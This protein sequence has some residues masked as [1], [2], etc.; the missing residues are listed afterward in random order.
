MTTNVSRV[1]SDREGGPVD[2]R[3]RSF[4][5]G[6]APPDEG[7]AR[8][9]CR[10]TPDAE[11]SGRS[12]S[13]SATQAAPSCRSRPLRAPVR[14]RSDASSGG[15][16]HRA[17]SICGAWQRVLRDV[18][19]GRDTD[20]SWSELS[21]LIHPLM[22]TWARHSVLRLRQPETDIEGI[23]QDAY[24]RLLG[25]NC[26]AMR[27]CRAHT[28]RQIRAYLRCVCENIATDRL[29]RDVSARRGGGRVVALDEWTEWGVAEEQSV[30]CR[31]SGRRLAPVHG[32]DDPEQSL[33]ARERLRS[34]ERDVDACAQVG[35][36]PERNAWIFRQAMVHG[37]RTRAIAAEVGLRCSS[38]DSVVGRMRR[39]LETRGWSFPRRT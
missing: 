10:R 8:E 31:R 3:L 7:R 20:R 28:E 4:R 1:P 27:R 38:V 9:G 30:G 2:V 13:T 18:E 17:G 25:G 24:V 37:R 6:T 21:E 22:S 32:T 33:F 29:R 12:A 19:A 5:D 39:R 23:V 11:A 35:R 26:L 36:K 15:V 16:P 34:F 14:S